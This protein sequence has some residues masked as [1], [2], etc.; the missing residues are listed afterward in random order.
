MSNAR[1]RGQK[2]LDEIQTKMNE[3]YEGWTLKSQDLMNNTDWEVFQNSVEVLQEDVKT[4]TSLQ[5]N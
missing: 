4:I 3:Y 2:Q 1:T 5:L